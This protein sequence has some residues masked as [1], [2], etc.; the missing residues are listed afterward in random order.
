MKTEELFLSIEQAKHLQE[1]GL[2]MSDAAFSWIPRKEEDRIVPTK[3]VFKEDE[4]IK[5]YT[6]TLQELLD[7]LPDDI[8]DECKNFNSLYIDKW[9]VLMYY[10]HILVDESIFKI[11]EFPIEE[12]LLKA[13]YNMLCWVIENGY[14]E[15]KIHKDIEL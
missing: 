4:N 8:I 14:L 9:E 2:D 10:A 12:S 11:V 3:Y 15:N 13:A 7:K 1:L 5:V 6:Y